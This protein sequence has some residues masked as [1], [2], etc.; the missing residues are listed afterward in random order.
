M[1]HYVFKY[2]TSKGIQAVSRNTN[3]IY[4]LEEALT[5][6]GFRC[7]GTPWAT[8]CNP[9]LETLRDDNDRPRIQI[10]DYLYKH[11]TQPN[12][13]LEDAALIIPR[14]YNANLET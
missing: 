8:D 7:V 14:E 5:N 10:V 4:N 13:N 3:V 12:T 11:P 2:D 9:K 6:V 1:N